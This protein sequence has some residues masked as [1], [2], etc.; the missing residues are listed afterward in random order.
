[1]RILSC[2]FF[3]I[4]VFSILAF[5]QNS[6]QRWQAIDI[7][8]VR[9]YVSELGT[10]GY[11]SSSNFGFYYPN[12]LTSYLA[13]ISAFMIG[14]EVENQPRISLAYWHSD[15][16]SGTMLTDSTYASSSD[17]TFRVYKLLKGWEYLVE[18]TIK[19]A[20]RKDYNEWPSLYGA[21]MNASGNPL[22]LGDMTLWMVNNDLDTSRHYSISGGNSLPLGAEVQTTIWAYKDIPELVNVVFVK[23]LIINKSKKVWKN[24][25]IGN[26]IEYSIASDY[27]GCDTNAQIGYGYSP[28]TTSKRFGNKIPAMGFA[29]LQGPIVP[30]TGDVAYQNGKSI[31]NYANLPMSSFVRF[32]YSNSLEYPPTTPQSWNNTLRG[33]W[34][35]GTTITNPKNGKP[36][37]FSFSGDPVTES[38]WT[39][40]SAGYLPQGERDGLVS[41]GPFTMAPGDTQ[42]VVGAFVIGQG[43]TNLES[44]NVLRYYARYAKSFY[45][46]GMKTLE[47]EAPSVG[48]AQFPNRIILDWNTNVEVSSHG[49][50]FQGYKVYQGES[51]DGPWYEIATYDIKDSLSVLM[52]ESFSSAVGYVIRQPKYILP[53]LGIRH[54]IEITRDSI[55]QTPLI[56]GTKYYF[57]VQAFANN[58]D[59]RPMVVESSLKGITAIPQSPV[60]GSTIPASNSLVAHS[61]P[62]DDGLKVRVINP[63]EMKNKK[64]K[65]EFSISKQDTLW[66]LYDITG[67]SAVFSNQHILES[68]SLYP[69]V[70]GFIPQ[71]TA[72][73]YG[74]RRDYQVP[75][76]WEYI[77]SNNR[78]FTGGTPDLLM[79]AKSIGLTWPSSG[80]YMGRPNQ[81]QADSLKRVEIRFN[82]QQPSKAYRYLSIGN[83][84]LPIRDSSFLPYIKKK[85][86][87]YT[88]QDFVDV[89]LSAWEID[90]NDGDTI[91]RQLAV[92][93]VETNDSLYDSQRKYLGRGNINGKWDPTTASNGGGE[94]LYILGRSY[95][96]QPDTPWIAKN[97]LTDT[98]PVLFVLW[99]KADSTLRED[100]KTTFDNGDKLI[101]QPNYP[102]RAGRVF[103]FETSAPILGNAQKAKEENILSR[104]IVYPNPYLGGHREE[105]SPLDR[106]VTINHLPAD[107]TIMIFTLAGTHIKTIKRQSAQNEYENWDLKNE[108]GVFVSSG[109]YIAHVDAPGIGATILKIALLMPEMRMRTY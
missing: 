86:P 57:A 23:R 94:I 41:T 36:T 14:A 93:F 97:L 54:F 31:S 45:T 18:G 34:K 16:Q 21:P 71:I 87:N 60:A 19:D 38:G 98:L 32:I 4:F 20:Y 90:P 79:D 22:Y 108:Q 105:S 69:V 47:W 11:G 58:K 55:Q 85:G 46:N 81:I 49:Y 68:D 96:E 89:P 73:G 5:G 42:E 48:I 92:A 37:T 78:F 50:T 24:T 59:G 63:Y 75:M 101:I 61:R 9:T 33:S 107:C 29:V 2:L 88:Y 102:L 74:V 53:N 104:T 99:C 17:S 43:A 83:I 6:N 7:N 30:S 103:E 66:S 1:M 15:F 44:I 51:T 100:K 56:N 25:Y 52:E 82:A 39:E 95:S 3:N 64:Y 109:I 28:L 80:T 76:G 62:Y 65:V 10:V 84:F 106:F 12:E 35:D 77:P 67:N 70:D 26:L 72:Y 40:T 91:P 13:Y 8:E 27:A